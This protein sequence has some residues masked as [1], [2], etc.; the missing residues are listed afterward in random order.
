MFIGGCDDPSAF[1]INPVIVEDTIEL[2]IPGSPAML[3]S[4]IDLVATGDSILGGRFPERVADA[5][6]WDLALRL[7]DG[8]LALVP[9]SALGLPSL[10]A[11]TRPI[12]DRSFDQI[13]R[14]PEQSSFL[15]D[16]AVVLRPG[17]AYVARA[18]TSAGRCFS[19]PR[20]SYAKLQPVEI[21]LERGTVRLRVVANANCTDPR[22]VAED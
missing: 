11:I 18:R 13:E 3:P 10:A 4:A 21:D 16:S 6:Q 15:A 20:V 22:L 7:R 9:S 19:A 5:T 12:T 8:E 1:E 14:A 2:A 17:A